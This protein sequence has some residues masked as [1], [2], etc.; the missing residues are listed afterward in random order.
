MHSDASCRILSVDDDQDSADS[1]AM[2]LE[3]RGHEVR[4]AYDGEAA[5][6]MAAS[7]RP[8]IVLLDLKMP[9]VDGFSVARAIRR[10]EGGG[11]VYIV[12]I[13]GRGAPDDV[14]RTRS[15][16]FDAQLVKPVDPEALQE[17]LAARCRWMHQNGHAETA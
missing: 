4:R 14:I 12:A 3:L 6:A 15:S 10:A 1:A 16:G 8:H 9:K 2:L 11:R 7:F 17:M 5:I 13:T